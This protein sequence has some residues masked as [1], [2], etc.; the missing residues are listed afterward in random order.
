[1][2][3]WGPVAPQK[4]SALLSRHHTDLHVR[5]GP[6]YMPESK[7]TYQNL[8]LFPSS[9]ERVQRLVLS[10]CPTESYFVFENFPRLCHYV[11]R[12]GISLPTF[13]HNLSGPIFR[14]Q[15]STYFWI[16]EP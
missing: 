3:H 11:E 8:D 15:E 5:L 1:M 6:S 9:G 4:L 13:R 16:L 2:A 12:S 7:T 14:G 10:S